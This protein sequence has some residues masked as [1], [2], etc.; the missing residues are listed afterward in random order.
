MAIIHTEPGVAPKTR[1]ELQADD[2]GLDFE[3]ARALAKQ[4]ALKTCSDAM[5]LS[6]LNGKTGACYPNHECGRSGKPPWVVFA[7]ARGANLTIDVNG[8]SYVFMFL[9]FS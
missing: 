8:G 7:E 4:E 9:A 3:T 2:T 5:L 6:W 1:I